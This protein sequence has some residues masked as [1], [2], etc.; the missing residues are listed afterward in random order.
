MFDTALFPLNFN[1]PD[2]RI[3]EMLGYLRHF[4]TRRLALLHVVEF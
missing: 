1:E 2:G 3:E 4:R